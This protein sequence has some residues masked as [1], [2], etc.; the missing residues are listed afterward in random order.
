MF[1]RTTLRARWVLALAIVSGAC[2]SG[3]AKSGDAGV[4][5][6][7]SVSLASFVDGAWRFEAD[8]AWH[9]QDSGVTLPSDPLDERDYQPMTP[10]KVYQVVLS[11]AGT[12]VTVGTTPYSGT[13][14]AASPDLLTFDLTT[15]TFA[16]GRFAVWP[17]HSSLQAELTIYGSGVPIVSSE[18]GA[19]TPSTP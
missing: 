6:A 1:E 11:Q 7:T 4:E 12:T 9:G 14:A 18:R 15:G 3:S 10:T 13:R 17:G 19:L 8:R 5:T 2:S 16:G